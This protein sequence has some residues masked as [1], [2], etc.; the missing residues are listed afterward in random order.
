[1]NNL[2]QDAPFRMAYSLHLPSTPAT[3]DLRRRWLGTRAYWLCQLAGWG[4]LFLVSVATLPFRKEPVGY[5][6][7]YTTA[8]V[9]LGVALSHLLRIAVLFLLRKPRSW[10]GLLARLAP[11]IVAAGMVQA[12]LLFWFLYFVPPRPNQAEADEALA[13]QT[14]LFYVDSLTLHVPIMT[15]WAGFYLGLRYYRQYQVTQIERLKLAASVKDAELRALKAQLNPHFLFNSLNTLRALIPRDLAQPREAIT[16]LSELLRAS[17]ASGHEETIPL[18]RELETVDNYL[19]L[20]K[21]RFENRVR[22][23]REIAPEAL[24][25]LVPPFL[26]Q[27]LVENAVKYGIATREAGGEITLAAAVEKDCLHVRITNPGTIAPAG[28]STGLG[29]ANSR[30]RLALLFGPAAALS[31]TQ[32]AADLVLAEAIIPA[33]TTAA[34]ANAP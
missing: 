29:L 7:F 10:P 19:A 30:A 11:W 18:A 33:A 12:S 27:T 3:H 5:D 1:M 26:V 16:L 34:A 25:R 8:M 15:I 31:L 4:G 21:L 20:E 6:I 28:D 32:A 17:L 22:I 24:S 23:R 13:T 2:V 9:L 14:S